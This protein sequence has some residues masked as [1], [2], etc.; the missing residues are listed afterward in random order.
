MIINKTRKKVIAEKAKLC[1]HHISKARG[2]MFSK[3]RA[4]IFPFR[5]EKII[6]L[7]MFFVFFPIDV[8][9]LDKKKEVVQLKENFRPFHIMIP[10]KPAKYII[11]LPAKMIKKT[12]TQL[13]DK[14]SF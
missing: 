10:K 3:K 4:L 8:L 14:I 6:S 9:F 11:E 13:G 1:K 7:H 5:K 12:K 2:L